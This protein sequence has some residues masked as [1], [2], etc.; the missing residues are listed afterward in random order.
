MG[1]LSDNKRTRE[2]SRDYLLYS[3][4]HQ[5]VQRWESTAKAVPFLLEL[6]QNPETP[7][8]HLL[9]PLLADFAVGSADGVYLHTGFHIDE[10]CSPEGTKEY[11]YF[12]FNDK[13]GSPEDFAY[14]QLLREIYEE[15]K[16]GLPL[17]LQL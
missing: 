2:H 14:G 12:V 1:L 11:G 7:E 16:K 17:Y 8:R 3:L 10:C 6:L 5:G 4:D 15:V 9:L 13:K